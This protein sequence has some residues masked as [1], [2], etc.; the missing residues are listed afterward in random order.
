MLLKFGTGLTRIPLPESGMGDF[1]LAV[2]HEDIPGSPPLLRARP[3]FHR[4]EMGKY[5]SADD[6]YRRMLESIAA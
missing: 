6:L 2:F 4:I 1:Q 5:A 3:C